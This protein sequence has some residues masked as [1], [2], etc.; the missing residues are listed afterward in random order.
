MARGGDVYHTMPKAGFG[1]F[2]GWGKQ[3]FLS[4]LYGLY[5]HNKAGVV[6]YHHTIMLKCQNRVL[7]PLLFRN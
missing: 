3:S 1:A 5:H 7:Y 2:R 4:R 6:R